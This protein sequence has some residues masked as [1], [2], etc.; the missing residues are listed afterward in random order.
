MIVYAED[1]R[2]EGICSNVRKTF[3]PQYIV[4][5]L[6]KLDRVI[7]SDVTFLISRNHEGLGKT[8]VYIS[9]E[10]NTDNYIVIRD[11]LN[12]DNYFS[13]TVIKEKKVIYCDYE[14]P[15]R[16]KF[17]DIIFKLF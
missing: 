10:C 1:G 8:K 12:D 15:S 6:E 2:I 5:E 16:E 9:A 11:S 14:Y 13:F 3:L 7:C 17:E 4:E